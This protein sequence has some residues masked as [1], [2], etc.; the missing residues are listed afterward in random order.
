MF[1]PANIFH[2]TVF[3]ILNYVWYYMI[4]IVCEFS[5]FSLLDGQ[6][7]YLLSQCSRVSSHQL[8][9]DNVLLCCGVADRGICSRS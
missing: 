2:Y 5:L 9:W 7:L 4:T 3:A 6:T 1:S 8:H